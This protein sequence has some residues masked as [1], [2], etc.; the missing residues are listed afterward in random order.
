MVDLSTF[1]IRILFAL[2]PMP[3]G[4]TLSC[5]L[6]YIERISKATRPIY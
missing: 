1:S 2:D 3:I 4:G 6:I 5:S